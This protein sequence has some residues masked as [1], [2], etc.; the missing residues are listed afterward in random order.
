VK[1]KVK[2]ETSENKNNRAIK[3]RS[4]AQN[5]KTPIDIN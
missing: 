3:S 1:I 5:C 4:K 2:N